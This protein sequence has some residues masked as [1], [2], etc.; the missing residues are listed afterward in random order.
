M[1]PAAKLPGV[2]NQGSPLRPSIPQCLSPIASLPDC[3]LF[4]QVSDGW[5]CNLGFPSMSCPLDCPRPPQSPQPSA[6]CSL[7]RCNFRPREPWRTLARGSST[8][9]RTSAVGTAN[10]PRFAFEA[11]VGS[12][13]RSTS[14]LADDPYFCGAR[15]RAS[16]RFDTTSSSAPELR[17]S[18]RLRHR[19]TEKSVWTDNSGHSKT[20]AAV[21]P[22]FLLACKTAS[23]P[24][25]PRSF[26]GLAGGFPSSR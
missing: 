2:Q 9:N 25:L 5:P 26:R 1:S 21:N 17:S 6:T 18:S 8:V 22:R 14:E 16:S 13:K 23:E 15:G 10:S 7:E 20:K 12:P 3:E 24:L 11:M 19:G 4:W